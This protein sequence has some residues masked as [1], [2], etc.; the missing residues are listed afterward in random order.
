MVNNS[1]KVRR[2][3]FEWNRKGN[4]VLDNYSCKAYHQIEILISQE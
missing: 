4:K 1:T 2:L 3:A